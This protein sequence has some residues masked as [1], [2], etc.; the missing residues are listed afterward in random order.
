MGWGNS[1]TDSSESFELLDLESDLPTTERDVEALW[2]LSKRMQK[3]TPEDANRLRDPY[4]TLEK[5]LAA[6]LF[7][8]SDEP[9]EL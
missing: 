2:Q 9:F 8:D 6:P 7:S 1:L 4:W 5:A 3:T